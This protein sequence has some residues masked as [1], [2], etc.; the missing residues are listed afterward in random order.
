M[1][2]RSLWDQEA[3]QCGGSWAWKKL[4][5]LRSLAQKFIVRKDGRETWKFPGGKYSAAAVWKEIRPRK[6][7]ITWHRLLWSPFVVPKH[8]VITWMA[9]L[10]RLPTKD[11]LRSWGIDIAG[12]S[13]L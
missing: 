1:K 13:S 4:L 9:I 2:G 6:E 7:K 10:N 11:R 12:V 5:K 3:N 8:A